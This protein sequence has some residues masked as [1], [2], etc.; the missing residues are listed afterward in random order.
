[1][2]QAIKINQAQKYMT[3]TDINLSPPSIKLILLGNFLTKPCSRHTIKDI[4]RVRANTVVKVH[5]HARFGLAIESPQ[6]EIRLPHFA[7]TWETIFN[8]T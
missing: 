5:L 4:F 7:H 8:P 1:M 6:G 3:S 2:S